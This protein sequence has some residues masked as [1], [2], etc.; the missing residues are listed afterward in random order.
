MS[1]YLYLILNFGSL[2]IPLLYSVLEK[3]FH[4]IQYFK[5]AFLSIVLVAIP[6]LIWDGIFTAQ[7]VWGFN[8]D[9]FIGIKIFKM[10]IEEWLFFF[11]IPY[12]CL[13][14]HEVLK[15]Y[16]P[17]FILPKITT[18]VLTILLLSTSFCLALFNIE[19]W[20][21]VINFTLFT[22][23]IAFSLIKHLDTLQEYYPSFLVILI[24]FLLVNGILTGSFIE[25]PVVWY[26]NSENLGF[27]VFTIPIED[28]F[29]AFTMLFSVQIIFNYLKNKH[30]E[31][32]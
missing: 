19:K 15:Y 26:N 28:F 22:I 6:F 5:K 13:F 27:R 18:I 16:F 17:N 24:P 29:Y 12:A 3:K 8:P 9:Y 7:G 1:Q 2:S 4:F 31:G 21:T 23:L 20:Y 10:P 25:E 14:T 32:K 30:F 11:C